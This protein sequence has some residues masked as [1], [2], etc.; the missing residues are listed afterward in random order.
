MS[1]L[2]CCLRGSS[3]A[4]A[5]IALAACAQHGSALLPAGA[6]GQTAVTPDLVPPDCKGQKT[7]KEYA[8]LTQT[9]STKGGSL[10][11]P[12]FGGFGGTIKYPPANPSVKLELTSST[13]NYDHMPS[14]GSGMPIFYMQLAIQGGTSFG[15]NVE[16]GGGLTG[17]QIDPH[18]PYTVYGQAVI[19]RIPFNFGPCYAKASKGKYGGVIGGVGTLL[20]GVQ[21]PGAAT[22]VVEIYPGKATGTKC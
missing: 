3:A 19:Y 21:I 16:A 8:S 1:F 22:A 17:K 14:L 5:L 7:T 15:N 12:A 6:L 13:T 18:K 10:C 2:R 4:V 20:R 9:L 11:V